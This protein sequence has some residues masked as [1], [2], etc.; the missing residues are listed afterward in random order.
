MWVCFWFGQEKHSVHHSNDHAWPMR[1]LSLIHLLTSAVSSSYGCHRAPWTLGHSLWQLVSLLGLCLF[2]AASLV[3]GF[4]I[5]LGVILRFSGDWLQGLSVDILGYL[6]HHHS[7]TIIILLDEPLFGRFMAWLMVFSSFIVGV[8][9]LASY[10]L[11][12]C[13]MVLYVH[14]V[15]LFGIQSISRHLPLWPFVRRFL[16]RLCIFYST[17]WSSWVSVLWEVV[18]S[19]WSL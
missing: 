1:W 4:A 9:N 5:F 15:G 17:I 18:I 11:G 2:L 3:N 10:K 8:M 19:F 16:S 14:F 13:T 12:I 6:L 7:Y